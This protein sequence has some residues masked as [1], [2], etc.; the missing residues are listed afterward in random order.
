[1]VLIDHL[2]IL[3]GIFAAIAIRLEL[4]PPELFE[5]WLVWRA[6]VTAA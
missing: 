2:L 1:M 3:V 6:A 4:R 5:W